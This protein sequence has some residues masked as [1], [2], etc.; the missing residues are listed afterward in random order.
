MSKGFS[1]EREVA[2]DLSLW[3]TRYERDD[4]IWRTSGSGARATNR[5]KRGLASAAGH[6][7]LTFTDPIAKPLFD[8]LFIENK[9][10]Y[11]NTSARLKPKQVKDTLK[12]MQGPIPNTKKKKTREQYQKELISK[13]FSKT[14]GTSRSVDILSH[15]DSFA[16]KDHLLDEWW[17]DAEEKRKQTDILFT[18]IIL[19]RD[20]RE[21]VVV[22]GLDLYNVI[23]IR[24]G[25]EIPAGKIILD[26]GAYK[27][28]ILPF[29][30]F[31][32][33]CTPEIIQS[34]L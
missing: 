33:W 14:K 6:G 12:K 13:L 7:D 30:Q 1:D 22:I 29:N 24:T 18:M 11:S 32:S 23:R 8:V 17:E 34:L 4:V 21:R 19:R 15:I 10:G 27:L 2:T 3:W 16:T 26:T 20:F 5:L 9:R 25:V 28:V 31:L